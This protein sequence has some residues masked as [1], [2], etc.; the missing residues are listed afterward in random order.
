MSL[1]SYRA[2]PPRGGF[3]AGTAEAGSRLQRFE[4]V[5]RRMWRIGFLGLD[6]VPARPGGD[7]LSRALRRSTIGAE[8]FHGRVRDGIGCW[9]LAIATR[10]CRDQ[11]VRNQ[12]IQ[13]YGSWRLVPERSVFTHGVGLVAASERALAVKRSI[14]RL[15]PVSTRV[16]TLAPPAYRRDGLSRLS[17]R[18]GF[19]GGF[20][21]RCFQR[22]SRPHIATRRCGWRHNRYT[23][24]ASIPV[25]SY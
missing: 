23:R 6:L 7:R 18:P 8:G 10:P 13:D 12:G 1:T 9:P 20:P 4:G 15:V 17:T 22:L 2:A 21:L 16:A 3:G 14:E 24:G 19:E 5:M 25:L 11:G